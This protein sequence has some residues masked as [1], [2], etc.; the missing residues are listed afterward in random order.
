MKLKTLMEWL[1]QNFF[2]EKLEGGRPNSTLIVLS[3]DYD[4]TWYGL[5]SKVSNYVCGIKLVEG[6]DTKINLKTR[7]E[8]CEWLFN[9]FIETGHQF[10]SNID[11]DIEVLIDGH[12]FTFGDIGHSDRNYYLELIE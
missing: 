6:D 9:Q 2:F 11:D 3:N 1:E 12:N 7:T 10:A 5:P 4:N 8:E